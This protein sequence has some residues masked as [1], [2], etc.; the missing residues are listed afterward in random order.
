MRDPAV[1][2][3]VARYYDRDSNYAGATFLDV[4]P[5]DPYAV[6]SG[7]LLALTLLSV[8]AEPRP[9]RQLL[10]MTATNREIRH[11]L[12]EEVLPLDA[13][14]AMATEETLLAMANLHEAAKRALAPHESHPSNRWVTAAKLCARKRPDL[15][16]VRDS[17]VCNLLGLS[18]TTQNYEV[19]WQVFRCIIQDADVRKRLDD[20]V[21]EASTRD[22]VNIG[23]PN[24]RLRHLD[25]VLWMHAQ[26]VS[27]TS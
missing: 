19:D 9:V 5:V 25:V 3:D 6:T 20:V 24:L 7:D 11:L 8:Q 14:L 2:D 4:G 27:R 21:D 16:P 17:V 12:T 10:E 15:F 22:G 18:G 23:H 13:D 26:R 1:V